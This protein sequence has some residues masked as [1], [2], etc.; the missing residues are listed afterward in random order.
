MIETWQ[1]DAIWISMAF[2]AGYAAKK[3]NL[4]PLIGFLATGFV[5][6]Y[7]NLTE[8]NIAIHVLSELGVMLLLFIIGLKLN[9]KSLLK[10]EIWGGAGIH[11]IFSTLVFASLISVLSIFGIGFLTELPFKTSLIIGF[12]LSFSSTVFTIK[13]LED[14]GEVSSFH[15]NMAIGILVIQDILAVVFL[16]A[17]KSQWPSI[18]ALGLP[19]YLWIVRWL[20]YRLL[21]T[22]GHGEMLTLFGFFAALVAGAMVFNLVGIKAD[23]GALILGMLLGQHNRAKELSYH[24]TGYK[25]FFLIAFFFE[26]GLSGLPNWDMVFIALILLVL[27]VFKGGLFMYIFTR[28]NIRARSSF[29]A[30][31]SLTTY[32]EFGLIV[33]AIGV[34]AGWLD[35]IWLVTIALALSFSFLLTAPFN[36]N[37]HSIFNRYKTRFMRLNT[38]KIHPD[39]EPSNLGDAQYLVC[40]IGRIGRSVYRQLE[41]SYGKKV[42]GIDY[43]FETVEKA[44]AEGKNVIWGDVT[45]SNFWQNA[46]L[47][48]IQMIFLSFTNHSS[49]VNTSIELNNI[50]HEN[51]KVGAVCEYRDQAKQLHDHGVDFIY[52]FRERVGEEFAK[53]FLL[54]HAS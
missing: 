39:D 28:F 6:N 51:I 7:L 2:L 42:L 53:E 14:R 47:Q 44:Q 26:I 24:M 17:S 4:P 3:I 21:R 37:A 34:E 20:F 38:C 32:S 12:A 19:L 49:N 45:D 35:G 25:D 33:A 15:G 27:V 13:I 52:N 40:G 22:I 16:T 8:G 9:V 5:L 43:N 31:M 41:N 36:H 23:L 18:Y 30:S 29:L 54:N 11:A 50:E 1:I 48:N 10:K 46:N